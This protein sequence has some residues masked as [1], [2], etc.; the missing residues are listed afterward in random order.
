VSVFYG[1]EMLALQTLS[2]T[3]QLAQM[4]DAEQMAIEF[5]TAFANLNMIRLAFSFIF[6]FIFGFLFYAAQFAAIGAAVTDDSDVQ[7]FTF[8]ITI[9]I[10]ISIILMSVTLQQP[11]STTAIWSS[12]IP[13][14]APIIMMARIP[15]DVPWWQQI[16]SMF[17]LIIS[18]LGMIYI[19]AKIYKIGILTQGKKITFKEIGKWIF[20]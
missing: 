15:F 2:N 6:Y 13:F 16:L 17:I 20:Y 4:S 14:S 5:S 11:S 19:A 3:N 9:P 12:M 1:T 7:S 18:C 10:I 8:P